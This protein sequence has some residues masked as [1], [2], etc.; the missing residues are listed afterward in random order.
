MK[1][2]IGLF[3]LISVSISCKKDNFEIESYTVSHSDIIGKWDMIRYQDL[4]AGDDRLKPDAAFSLG[5]MIVE[6]KADSTIVGRE[7]C[8][9][10]SGKFLINSQ[11]IQF[12]KTA[13]TLVGCNLSWISLFY[14]VFDANQMCYINKSGDI[15][16]LISENKYK[17][18]TLKK[19]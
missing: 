5:S 14:N 3:I 6:F 11:R 10:I 7:N 19:I 4:D 17:K 9:S 13:S 2:L 18:V 16:T 12:S 1:K 15:I 8:N